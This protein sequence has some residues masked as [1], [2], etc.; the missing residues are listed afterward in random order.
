[1]YPGSLSLIFNWSVPGHENLFNVRRC[2]MYTDVQFDRFHCTCIHVRGESLDSLE[3]TSW[4][5]QGSP[6]YLYCRSNFLA[7]Y[8]HLLF[9]DGIT[10]EF[11]R[12]WMHE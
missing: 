1:M 5:G 11:I 7:R 9:E 10:C 12:A 4:T 6:L 3:T 2:S 8:C